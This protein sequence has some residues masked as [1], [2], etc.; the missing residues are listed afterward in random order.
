MTFTIDVPIA[1]G[2]L[3]HKVEAES[4]EEAIEKLL[5]YEPVF[6]EPEYSVVLDLDTNK[7]EVSSDE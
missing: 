2:Y 3:S 1:S 7:W 5:A 4:K 6:E